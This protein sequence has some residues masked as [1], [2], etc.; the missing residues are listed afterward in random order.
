M[1]LPYGPSIPPSTR[2]LGVEPENHST[3]NR[4]SSCATGRRKRPRSFRAI[5]HK[6]ARESDERFFVR[7]RCKTAGILCVLQG[8]TNAFPTKKIRQ[9]PKTHLCGVAQGFT[10]EFL[11]KKSSRGP[12]QS[13]TKWVWWGKEAQRSD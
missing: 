8:F 11:A 10:N 3:R 1:M 2:P 13:P 5:P 6:S 12:H 7:K 4:S 9:N